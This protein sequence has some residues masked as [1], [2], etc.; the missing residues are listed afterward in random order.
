MVP[1]APPVILPVQDRFPVV[2]ASVMVQRVFGEASASLKVSVP[3][4]PAVAREITALGSVKAISVSHPVPIL[5]A[6]S[7]P[8]EVVIFPIFTPVVEPVLV[9]AGGLKEKPV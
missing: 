7:V 1:V 2:P 3:L 5:M 4:V 6:V 9:E 8:F